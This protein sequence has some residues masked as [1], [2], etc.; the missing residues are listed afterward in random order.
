[1]VFYKFR[2]T[3]IKKFNNFF[4][5][6]PYSKGFSKYD[7]LIY[8]DIFPHPI[9]G[10]R[11]EEFRALL[12]NFIKSKIILEPLAYPLVKTEVEIHKV[13][14]KDFI[15]KFPELKSK[16]KLKNSGINVNTKFFYCIFL[17]NIYNNL[18]WLEKYNIPFIFTLYPGGGFQVGDAMSDQKMLKVFA[19]KQFKKVIVTQLYTKNYLI[20]NDFCASN[21]IEYIF[22]GV[23]PQVSL[24]T[25]LKAKKNYPE[26]ETFDII[27]CAAKYMPKGLDKGYD[28][29]IELA[30][31]VIKKHDFVRFHVVGGFDRE[32]IDVS[33]LGRNI[34]FYG[35]QKFEDLASIY[36]GMDVILSPN[37]P[38]FLGT[39]AFDGFPL[40][41]VVEAVLNG[42]VALITDKLEQNTVFEERE[43]I[44]IIDDNVDAIEKILIDLIEHPSKLKNIAVQGRNK[45]LKIYSNE[46]QMN[47]RI[48]LLR[49]EIEKQ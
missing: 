16:L 10:F 44:I 9:S 26:K 27:F 35:Y 5:S 25:D 7:L 6:K 34:T 15:S 4:N 41:T 19:S 43:E 32:E 46:Y 48:Q 22:G 21:K 39:G 17:N 37:K 29:F 20:K 47:P 18:E 31:S 28:V 30:H 23:V 2:R 1:M 40:G 36:K 8:D 38:F 45:F 14:I 12:Y 33:L 11:Y 3:F 42:V 24:N 13:H 49:N